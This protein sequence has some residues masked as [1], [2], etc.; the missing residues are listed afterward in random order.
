VL[1]HH[2]NAGYTEA[3]GIRLATGRLLTDGDV[4]SAAP[5]ALV[6]ERFVRMRVNGR[7]PLGLTV[8]LPRLKTPPFS[9][10]NDTVQIVGVVRDTLNDGLIDPIVPE[11]YLPF[12]LIG[13]SNVLVVRTAGDPAAATKSIVGQVYAIDKG[14]PVTNVMTLD[15]IIQDELY[16][17]P[18]FNFVLLSV[19]AAVGLVLA[20]VGV[21]GLMSSAVAQERQEI[22][23][24]MALGAN[25]GSIARMIVARGLKLLLLGTVVGLA[26][27]YAVGRWLAGEVW[28]VATFD[29]LAFAAVSALL[30][31][32]GLQACA[33]PALRAAR[34]DPLVA[35]RT[36]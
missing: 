1:I 26:G 11:M 30:L 14:Q 5:V 22:G 36:D 16:A 2:V 6:N 13:L 27:S 9:M 24:R 19:F 33:W 10:T 32:A 3:F 18:R 7:E 8:S 4:S 17:T 29:P 23:V 15:R 12:T 25:A 20:V 21:Y 34:T 35:L 28:N 31:A